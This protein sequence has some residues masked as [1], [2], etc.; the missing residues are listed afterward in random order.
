M[1]S[2]LTFCETFRIDLVVFCWGVQNRLG[3][4]VQNREQSQTQLFLF[5]TRNNV[6]KSILLTKGLRSKCVILF[7]LL[8]LVK[9]PVFYVL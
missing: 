6:Y 8:N 3:R 1:L 2:I 7:V 9:D 5:T 4:G